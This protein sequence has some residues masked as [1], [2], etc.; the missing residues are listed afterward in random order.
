MIQ[1][2]LVV[3]VVE[4]ICVFVVGNDG[5]VGVVLLWFGNIE[6]VGFIFFG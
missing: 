4:V 6:G 2:M 5:L 3:V 1:E